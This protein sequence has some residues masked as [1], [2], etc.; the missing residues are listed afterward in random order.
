[1]E[2][3]VLR[4]RKARAVGLIL[5]YAAGIATLGLFWLPGL[6]YRG[7]HRLVRVTA[8]ASSR[9]VSSA[10]GDV[11]QPRPEGMRLLRQAQRNG[12]EDN[13]RNGHADAHRDKEEVTATEQMK[14]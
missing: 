7:L 4:S 5:R 10:H 2:T 13:G 12:A 11:K 1:K 6:L 14:S 8:A 3:D 9:P